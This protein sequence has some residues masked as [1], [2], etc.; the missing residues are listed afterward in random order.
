MR[1]QAVPVRG[2]GVPSE[3]N[4][5]AAE[6]DVEEGDEVHEDEESRHRPE[7]L[8]VDFLGTGDALQ[9][10]VS[11]AISRGRSSEGRGL[12]I[13]MKAI[14]NLTGMM[15]R[16]KKTSKK[17]NHFIAVWVCCSSRLSLWTP[18]PRKEEPRQKM[19]R[20][21]YGIFLNASALV[22]GF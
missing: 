2:A 6:D 1:G 22:W 4:R 13:N 14:L 5:T 9:V 12:T 15:A 11:G 16:Q 10:V 7:G 21:V 19:L 18:T 17:K 3:G 20:A 8:V